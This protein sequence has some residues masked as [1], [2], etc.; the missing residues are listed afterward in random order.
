[1]IEDAELIESAK[2]PFELNVESEDTDVLI[3]SD[4]GMDSR[5]WSILNTAARS[6]DLEPTVTLMPATDHPQA[7]P[8]EQVKEAMLASDICVMV[9]SNAIVHSDAAV[10]V[11]EN[12]IPVIGMEEIT[13]EILKGGAAS[14]N[15]ESF[16]ETGRKLRDKFVEGE[17]ISITTPSGT[18]LEA[19]IKDRVGFSFAAKIEEQPGDN[20]MLGAAFPDGEVCISPNE[21][22]A[23]GTIVWDTSMH[24]IGSI[25][26]PIEAKIEDGF[27]TSITGG[28]EAELLR[29]ILEDTNDPNSYNLAE[30]AVGIN[31]GADITGLMRQDKKAEGYAHMALGSNDD[32]G[33]E[34]AAPIHIDGIAKDPTV[35]IDGEVIYDGKPVV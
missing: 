3:V 29:S 8:T 35:K 14:A 21:N 1:M 6:L 32:T 34:L 4:T 12:G 5:V 19:D 22:T 15:Y 18:D 11:R 10:E 2:I 17:T 16:A 25:T 7:E 28:Q 24:Q 9:T 27:A 13:P 20:S 30:I 23:N 26:E 33:G 31:T